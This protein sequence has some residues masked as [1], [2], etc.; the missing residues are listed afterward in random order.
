MR[1]EIIPGSGTNGPIPSGPVPNGP[2]PNGGTGEQTDTREQ[3]SLFGEE[4]QTVSTCQ[5]H[6]QGNQNEPGILELLVQGYRTEMEQKSESEG[7]HRSKSEDPQKSM[8]A[9][10]G[11]AA[12]LSDLLA[13]EA[14]EKSEDH[15]PKRNFGFMG[16]DITDADEYGHRDKIQKQRMVIHTCGYCSKKTSASA[17]RDGDVPIRWE[18]S[19]NNQILC[20]GCIPNGVMLS[21]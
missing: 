17:G 12:T 5:R 11:T 16:L 7:A 2:V 18:C 19:A 9:L 14:I 21:L 3:T 13:A 10:E 20:Q 15:A 6:T 1:K 8:T 4:L